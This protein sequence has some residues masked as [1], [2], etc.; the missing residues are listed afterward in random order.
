MQIIGVRHHHTVV[1]PD[2]SIRLLPDEQ[3]HPDIHDSIT[4][5]LLIYNTPLTAAFVRAAKSERR[6]TATA[7][8]L[9][10][11]ELNP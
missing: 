4:A 8:Q 7:V 2:S 5:L 9:K 10:P 3:Q 11:T 6:W 1:V